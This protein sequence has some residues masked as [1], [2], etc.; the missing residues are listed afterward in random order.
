MFAR[1]K[2]FSADVGCAFDKSMC[3]CVTIGV[4]LHVRKIMKRFMENIRLDRL[5][6]SNDFLLK[7]KDI[8]ISYM[9]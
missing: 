2:T 5:L 3:V 1:V 7:V 4:C 8:Q 6:L 9:K